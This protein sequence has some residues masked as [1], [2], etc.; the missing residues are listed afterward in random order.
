[1]YLRC[2]IISFEFKMNIWKGR[3][4]YV[5]RW[6]AVIALLVVIFLGQVNVKA[7]SVS[8]QLQVQRDQL[9]K[10][11]EVLRKAREQRESLEIKVE[12]MD[13]QIESIMT[14]IESNK[15]SILQ[16][17]GMVK[18]VETQIGILDKE[19]EEDQEL[20]DKRV[21]AIYIT[22]SDSYVKVLLDSDGFS[23]FMSRMEGISRV[24]AYDRNIINDI[25]Q[26]QSIAATKKKELLDRRVELSDLKSSNEQKLKDMDSTIKEQKKL[27]EDLKKQEQVYASDAAETKSEIDELLRQINVYNISSVQPDSSRG[28]LNLFGNEVIAYAAGFIGTPYVWGGTTVNP[29][30]DCSG[31]TQYVYA[32]FGVKLGRTTYDQIKDGISIARDQLQPGDLVFFGTADN[33]HHMGIYVGNNFF[34]HAPRT[35]DVIKISPM[36]RSD[37]L[38]A[39]RVK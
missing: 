16:I 6:G 25:K 35:G 9:Q 18:E 32:H 28:N 8:M 36:T 13:N 7:E 37:Y 2:A 21:R 19:I 30:F 12:D 27:L 14:L 34:I 29:G 11:E 4:P 20:L 23:D 24:I 39:R 26:K 38:T 17:E 15:Q 5:R 3:I 33:P 22:G 10:D 1:M 31:F